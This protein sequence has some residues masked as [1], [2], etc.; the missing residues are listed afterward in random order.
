MNSLVS[1]EKNI[2]EELSNSFKDFLKIL[3]TTDIN[4]LDD[5]ST[6]NLTEKI[7]NINQS[8]DYI[9]L[10][11]NSLNAELYA[12]NI[13]PSYLAKEYYEHEKKNDDTIKAFMPYMMFYNMFVQNQDSSN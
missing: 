10:Q 7:K 12:S 1:N 2:L 11:I 3:D 13:T 5:V 4:E 6:N 9:T 8:M